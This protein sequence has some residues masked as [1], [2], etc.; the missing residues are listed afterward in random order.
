MKFAYVLLSVLVDFCKTSIMCY[1]AK[2]MNCFANATNYESAKGYV[3]SAYEIAE[4]GEFTSKG[5]VAVYGEDAI[6]YAQN[7]DDDSVDFFSQDYR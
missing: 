5:A 7:M 1:H 2:T 3:F 4:G 6:K